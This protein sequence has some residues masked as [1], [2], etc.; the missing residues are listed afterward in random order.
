MNPTY[1]K[2]LLAGLATAAVLAAATAP[3]A[4]ATTLERL[5][6]TQ[7]ASAADL[8]VRARC[9]ATASRWER[10]SIWTISDFEVLE[11][12]KGTP[13]A[14]LAVRVPGGRIG[15]LA[16]NVEA[17]PKFRSGE[18][19]I[20]FLEKTALGDYAVTGWT[21]GTFRIRQRNA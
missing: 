20:L 3:R 13:P 12:Y 18:E 1:G 17:A 8:V 5:S 6:L 2:L 21:E 10:G 19:G 15:H 9:T 16:M 14:Q 11:H 7:L 4:S